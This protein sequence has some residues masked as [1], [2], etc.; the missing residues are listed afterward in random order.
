MHIETRSRLNIKE[1]DAVRRQAITAAINDIN[2][3]KIEKTA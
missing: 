1:P 3:E 2:A